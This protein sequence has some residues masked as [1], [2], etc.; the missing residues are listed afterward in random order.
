MPITPNIIQTAKHTVNA[1][2]LTSRTIMGL[3]SDMI[4]PDKRLRKRISTIIRPKES[5]GDTVFFGQNVVD[6]MIE[7]AEFIRRLRRV[8]EGG[9]DMSKRDV[10]KFDCS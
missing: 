1:R 9:F 7:V 5:S 4:G 6:L 2:V 3:A 10:R 8:L